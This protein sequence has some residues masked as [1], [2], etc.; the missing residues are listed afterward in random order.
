MKTVCD[1]LQSDTLL[2]V[3][4]VPPTTGKSVLAGVFWPAWHWIDHPETLWQYVSYDLDLLNRDSG[5]L[6]SLL[7][8]DWYI[9][10]W[11]PRLKEKLPAESNF[12]I[13]G[14]GGRQNTT[15][16]AA[17]TGWHAHKQVFDDPL[18]AADAQSTSGI[19][20]AR[21]WDTI[22]DTF[23][24]RYVDMATFQRTIIGQRLAA[25][26]PSGCALEQGWLGLRLPMEHDP[27]R[28]DP[29]DHRIE[30]GESLAPARFSVEAIAA[31]KRQMPPATWSAQYQQDPQAKGGN[32][33]EEEWLHCYE[34]DPEE[35]RALCWYK[36]QSWD[37]AF[38]GD[39]SSDHIA[40]QWWG[41]G[42][43][44]P[45]LPGYEE[46]IAA[47]EPWFYELD[48]PVNKPLTFTE[49]LNAMRSKKGLWRCTKIFIE[50]KANGPAVENT[51][52]ARWPGVLEMVNPKGGKAARAVGVSDLFSS[53]RVWFHP[54]SSW[55]ARKDI[56]HRFPRVRRDDLVDA[57]TQALSQMRDLSL[58]GL[59][60]Q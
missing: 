20:L 41:V 19:E 32:I 34:R 4:N 24:S 59:L 27:E 28:R 30:P 55:P 6:I 51:L 44:L 17:A 23:A 56:Y 5:Q 38:K 14:G 54:G 13:L 60:S 42:P 45:G 46:S 9:E 25:A 33:F 3:V 57:T 53:H 43:P 37:L 47:G 35:I 7:R 48:E 58:L 39:E 31:L 16:K 10:R 11:G 8:S 40:G 26:D 50:D 52:K 18:K 15:L 12:K 29:C 49:T 36:A 1:F 2:R 21:A 22:G